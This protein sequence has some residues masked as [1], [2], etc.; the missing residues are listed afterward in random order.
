MR[1]AELEQTNVELSIGITERQR[2]ITRLKIQQEQVRTQCTYIHM[3][4]YSKLGHRMIQ[5]NVV[6]CGVVW[7]TV[8][9]VVLCDVMGWGAV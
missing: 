6:W 1:Q 4:Y 8:L 3:L 2:E 7:C 9:C 5:C